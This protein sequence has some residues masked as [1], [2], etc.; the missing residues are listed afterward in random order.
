MNS[1]LFKT[2]II[3]DLLL[4]PL[5]TIEPSTFNSSVHTKLTAISDLCKIDMVVVILQSIYSW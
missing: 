2:R 3:H 4:L 1:L 5:E